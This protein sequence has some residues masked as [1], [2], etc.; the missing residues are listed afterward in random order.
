MYAKIR[1]LIVGIFLC[2]TCGVLAELNP[3]PPSGNYPSAHV[4]MGYPFVFEDEALTN[5]E[6]N[7]I[8][9]DYKSMWELSPPIGAYDYDS[10]SM[11]L[12][13][14]SA[15]LLT[16]RSRQR[17]GLSVNETVYRGELNQFGTMDGHGYIL[18]ISKVLSDGYRSKIQLPDFE[19]AYAALEEFFHTLNHLEES[20]LKSV[21]DVLAIYGDSVETL[22]SMNISYY[23]E[24]AR[25]GQYRPTSVLNFSIGKDE[26]ADQLVSEMEVRKENSPYNADW[27]AWPIVYTENGWRIYVST[28]ME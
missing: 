21:G 25:G 5:E 10:G 27:M 3:L 23:I 13:N 22:S 6:K 9:D 2:C 26:L 11:L 12:P 17:D 1:H 8:F 19:V 7:F 15:V 18:V 16:C 14:G 20:N 4:L 24:D 28:N